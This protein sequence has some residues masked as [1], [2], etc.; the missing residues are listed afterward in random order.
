M[1]TDG[2]DIDGVDID[3]VEPEC[4]SIVSPSFAL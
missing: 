1:C 2:V 4:S 3:G